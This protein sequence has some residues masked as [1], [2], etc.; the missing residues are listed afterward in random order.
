MCDVCASGEV[1]EWGG[2]CDVYVSREC[3]S[4]KCVSGEVSVMCV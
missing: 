1:C 4:G 3:V 2:E